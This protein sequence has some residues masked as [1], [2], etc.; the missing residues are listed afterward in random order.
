MAWTWAIT[1]G[2]GSIVPYVY[3]V[4]LT[5]LLLHR[6]RRDERMCRAKYG[7]DW[8]RYCERVRYA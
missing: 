2:L 7:A 1:C 4:Y 3:P 5:S 6:Q 8:A